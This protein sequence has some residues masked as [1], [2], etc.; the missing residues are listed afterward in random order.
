ML[1]E[2]CCQHLFRS[3]LPDIDPNRQG[4]AF[5]IGVGTF[6]FFCETFAKLKFPTIAVEPLPTDELKRLASRLGIRLIISALSDV[7]GMVTLY[8]GTYDGAENYNLNSLHANWWGGSTET[9]QV[10]STTLPK[11]LEQVKVNKITCMKIDVEGAEFTIMSQFLS[12]AEELLPSVVMFEYGGGAQ[13]NEGQGGW[14]EE[15]STS[16]KNCLELL[17]RCGFEDAIV[18]ESNSSQE[19]ILNLQTA[20]LDESEFFNPTD[21]YGNIIVFRQFHPDRK[22]ISAI[23]REYANNNSPSQSRVAKLLK[24]PRKLIERK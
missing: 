13:Q 18:I 4:T 24:I 5:D 9:R 21:V 16:T 23:C 7:D 3:L 22:K 19:R 10:P 6:S 12:L 17:K 15:Y 20:S 11:L 2:E 14:S 1:V 8:V